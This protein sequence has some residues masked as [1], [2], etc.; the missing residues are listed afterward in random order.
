LKKVGAR[1]EKKF[2]KKIL[3]FKKKLLIL[4]PNKIEFFEKREHKR[5][6]ETLSSTAL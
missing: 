6:K 2:F 1:E 3:L 4:C 5:E